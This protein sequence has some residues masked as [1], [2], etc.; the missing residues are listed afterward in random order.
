[1]QTIV[2]SSHQI[3]EYGIFARNKQA[4]IQS[5]IDAGKISPRYPNSERGHFIGKIG[6]SAVF[7]W[8]WINSYEPVD[9]SVLTDSDCDIFLKARRLRLEVKCW[10]VENWQWGGRAINIHQMESV[11]KKAH[12]IIWC[13]VDV[14][15]CKAFLMGWSDIKDFDRAPMVRK[16]NLVSYQLKTIR[17]METF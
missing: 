2:L 4:R 1:M 15:A 14:E 8:A 12:R 10:R 3:A 6:E 16:N 5:L 17:E 11:R 13:S 9:R 7:E